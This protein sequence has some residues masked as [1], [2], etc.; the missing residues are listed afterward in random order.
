MRP[1]FARAVTFATLAAGSVGGVL[2][3]GGLF[4]A[5]AT[6]KTVSLLGCAAF[7]VFAVLA[8]RAAAAELTAL[9][10]TH[11]GEAHA[12]VLGLIVVFAGYGLTASVLLFL[13]EVPV[14]RMLVSGAVTGVIFGIAAQQSL[15]N[16]VAGLVLLL[17]RPFR[18][19]DS[20]TVHSGA[21]G[22]PLQGQ[23]LAL[24]LTYVRLATDEGVLCVP[25]SGLLAAAVRQGI[26][27]PA[28][29]PSCDLTPPAPLPARDSTAAPDLYQPATA[30][31]T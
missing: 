3:F 6:E 24:G 12:S 14:E 17:N 30:L 11:F 25:N 1:A 8:V 27:E 7:T 2:G 9:S 15:G 18:L 21:L 22:G 23:V 16:V 13:L 20:I 4:S 28:L 31:L 19:G 29:T 10:Q 5:S 26:L